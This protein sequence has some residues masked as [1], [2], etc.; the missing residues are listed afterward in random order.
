MFLIN[1]T[2]DAPSSSSS[3]RNIFDVVYNKKHKIFII[4]TLEITSYVAVTLAPILYLHFHILDI[5]FAL[6]NFSLFVQILHESYQGT[7]FS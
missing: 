6:V 7:D 4:H 1:K 5:Q 2:N 3:D